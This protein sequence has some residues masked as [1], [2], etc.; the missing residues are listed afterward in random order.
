MIRAHASE[1]P[2]LR[3]TVSFGTPLVIAMALGALFNLVDLWIVAGYQ[4][5]SVSVAAAT[6]GSLVNS[7]PQIIF[8]GIVNAMLAL[9][10]RYHALGSV[11]KAGVAAGQGLT[12]TVLM[13]LLMG[14]PPAIYAEEIC[15]AMGATDRAVLD[16]ATDYLAIMSWG[17][18]TMFLLLHVT[19]VLRAVGNSLIPLLLLGAANLLNILLDYV[20]IYGKFG[21][22]ELG[23]A[24]A[25]W[26]TVI[27]RGVFA[28]AGLLLLYRGFLGIRLRRWMWRG[29]IMW[30]LLK[31]GV[32]SC[33]QWLV[34]MVSYLYILGFVATAAPLAGDL[35]TDAQAAFGVGLRLDSL[36][37]FSGCGWGA[38]AATLV[39]QNLG[40]GRRD[41]AIRASWIALG[42][43]MCMMLIFAGAYVLFADPLL[44]TMNFDAAATGASAGAV[45][46]IGRTYLYLAS[47]GYVFL[48]IAVTLSQALAGAGA[49]KFPLLIEL[50]A[51]GAIGYPLL[52]WA[53]ENADRFGLRGMWLAA[54]AL[55]LGVAV[56]YLVWFKIGVWARKEL[57]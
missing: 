2:L 32:P 22:P 39:G 51:Y 14:V 12:L 31:I 7:I 38:A 1:P 30:A 18:I 15:L 24:G 10:A 44:A 21:F 3:Q 57:R 56:A 50:I 46:D 49:T 23:V 40:R 36:V 43:N 16:P 17:T 4:D 20:L 53:A 35:V 28:I 55:H 37:L 13:A 11:H 25:A 52:G 8:N 41:R 27:A 45:M 42:L 6:I 5:P 54:V 26:A 29:R 9:V 47:A 34:R 33:I 19:G 48:A